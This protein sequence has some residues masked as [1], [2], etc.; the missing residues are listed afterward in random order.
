M[1]KKSFFGI[2]AKLALMLIAICGM[3]A[4]CY[5]KEEL[6]TEAPST[7][8]PVYKITGV[9]S[10]AST[11]EPLSGAKVNSA[12]TGTDGIYTIEAAVGLNVLT[13]TKA[14]YKTVTTSVYVEAIENGKTAVY[15]ANAAMY[16]GYDTPSYK[17]VKYNIKGTA[18]DESGAAVALSSV[19]MPGYTVVPNGNTF[20]VEGV[21]PGTYYVVLTAKGYKNA[22]ASI[23][24]APVT[25]EEGEGD[26]IEISSVGVLM[27]KEDVAEV[28][29]Y[30]VCGFV[31]NDNNEP[32]NGAKVK[33]E[34]GAFAM[35]NLITDNRGYFNVE[36]PSQHVT[37]TTLAV[38]TVTKGGYI[39]LVKASLLKLVEAGA[40]SVTS[41]EFVLKAEGEIIPPEDP[42]QGGE[43]TV[44]VDV[45]KQEEKDIEEIK[46]DETPEV[47]NKIEEIAKEMGNEGQV[48]PT[49]PVEEALVVELISTEAILDENT[50]ET[51]QETQQVT[52]Q[53]Q[54]PAKTTV[55]YVGGTAEPISVVRDIKAE[56]TTASVRTYE[57][58]PS[59]TVFSQPMEI[60]FQA[61]VA[62]TNEP[63]YVLGVLYLN[64]KT[65][66]WKADPDNYAEYDKDSKAFVGKISHFSKFRF[67]LESA[68]N[69]KD[70]TYL[71]AE[72]IGKPCYTGS[73][74]AVI[75]LKGQY[76][77]GT[78]FDGNTPSMAVKAALGNMNDETQKYVTILLN[79]M[80]KADYANIMPANKYV[81]TNVSE[82]FVVPAFKQINDFS[83]VR[84][85]VKKSY[86][87]HVIGKDKQ[88]TDVTVIVKRIVG[89]TIEA[90]YAIG[91]THGHGNGEDLNAGGG[92]IEFE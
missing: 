69:P 13:I 33:V 15:T 20:T 48:I 14:D 79:N 70:S 23:N 87:V 30:F 35:D 17:T 49:V 34:V 12:T 24:V 7:V 75:T 51:T 55:Y 2:N 92:I 65:G 80:I 67:G 72:T 16:P 21:Q 26:Q 61:P 36:I 4:S 60:K 76:Q 47:V 39:T 90:N 27:Q 43:T 32:V 38:V 11:G 50:G 53:I 83:M 6:T 86:T 19:V 56:K 44:P 1:K 78:A 74:S 37:P 52:D 57:G 71:D 42:S 45:T 58:Q 40:T 22:Y 54:L 64:E 3:F 68:I 5:E 63:D 9:I 66:E 41:L 85:Q 77:G 81:K 73:A 10:D 88:V 31:T 91:H 46:K 84:K 89:V 25:A 29:K 18:T 59:G 82:D 28:S 62:I 8:A